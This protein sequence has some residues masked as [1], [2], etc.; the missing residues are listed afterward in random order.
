MGSAVDISS[1]VASWFSALVTAIGLST[2]IVQAGVI[3]AHVDPFYKAR[4]PEQ[5]G[6]WS[7]KKESYMSDIL[8]NRTLRGPTLKGDLEGLNKLSV[9]YLSRLPEGTLGLDYGATTWTRLCHTLHELRTTSWS[10]E[11]FNVHGQD[12][13]GSVSSAQ[14]TDVEE[15]SLQDLKAEISRKAS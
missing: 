12:T 4:G 13:Y 1:V 3:R 8:R 9:I 14:M 7:P 2:L 11:L 10:P 5:L 15:S 6:H